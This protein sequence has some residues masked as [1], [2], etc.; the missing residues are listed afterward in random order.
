MMGLDAFGAILG[1][2]N[3]F[4]YVIDKLL[5]IPRHPANDA[6]SKPTPPIISSE[7]E[8]QNI[9]IQEMHDRLFGNS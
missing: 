8:A 4:L 5:S 3:L 2:L 1:I 9:K 6:I 7:S